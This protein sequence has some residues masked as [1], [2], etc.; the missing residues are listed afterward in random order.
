MKT[1]LQD[2]CEQTTADCYGVKVE[3]LNEANFGIDWNN[4]TKF[5]ETIAQIV[6]EIM[7]KC[8]MKKQ[9]TQSVKNPTWFQRARFRTLVKQHCDACDNAKVKSLSGK[10]AQCCMNHSAK[11]T[12]D[13]VGLVAD[14]V[15]STENW[16][17]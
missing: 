17:I 14:E 1:K 13:E 3:D 11:L 10:L 4:V 9:L 8:P 6:M 5:I 7:T 15:L 16:L 2:F 12:E